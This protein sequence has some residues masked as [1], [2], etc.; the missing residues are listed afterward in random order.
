KRREYHGLVPI[1]RRVLLLQPIRNAAH[2]R[3]SLVEPRVRLE[4]S[5]DEIVVPASG[6]LRQHTSR[7]PD[8]CLPGILEDDGRDAHDFERSRGSDLPTNGVA[9]LSEVGDGP[10]VADDGDGRAILLRGPET[11]GRRRHA[12]HAEEVRRRELDGSERGFP[13]GNDTELAAAVVGH[14][15]E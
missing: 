8:V 7:K 11:A 12:E 3:S 4:P 14:R 6:A 13:F 15:L 9:R 5:Y 1:A 10:V 2:F